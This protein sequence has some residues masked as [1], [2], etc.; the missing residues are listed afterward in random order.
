MCDSGRDVER[1]AFWDEPPPHV[2]E[3]TTIEVPNG[4]PACWQPPAP[5]IKPAV[6]WRGPAST[7]QPT[8][9]SGPAIDGAEVDHAAVLVEEDP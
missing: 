4:V 3:L 2:L 5:M 8:R 6:D 1:D 9:E 7:D